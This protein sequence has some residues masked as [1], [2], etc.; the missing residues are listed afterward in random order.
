MRL[1]FS[2]SLL[3]NFVQRKAR[4]TTASF[5][6]HLPPS[7]TRRRS[8][9]CRLLPCSNRTAA[10]PS[11][12]YHHLSLMHSLLNRVET[13]ERTSGLAFPFRYSRLL[14]CFCWPPAGVPPRSRVPTSESL[15]PKRKP[16]VAPF[17]HL[18]FFL[19]SYAYTYI[20]LLSV[21]LFS[22]LFSP[23][24]SSFSLS[25][26]LFHPLISSGSL[27]RWFGSRRGFR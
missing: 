27:P 8:R 26:K 5:H 21:S 19:S 2:F 15:F 17:R 14:L 16:N 25:P 7:S 3:A 23:L 24:F 10:R 20:L 9:G 13:A 4:G 12:N 11:S 1:F 18:S 6:V 22:F